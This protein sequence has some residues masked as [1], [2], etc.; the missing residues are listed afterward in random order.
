MEDLVFSG[1]VARPA[2]KLDLRPRDALVSA[3]MTFWRCLFLI[4]LVPGNLRGDEDTWEHRLASRFSGRLQRLELELSSI[5]ETLPGLPDVPLADQGGSGGFVSLHSQAEPPENGEFSV[6]VRFPSSG[7]V[8]LVV[9]V[10]ARRYGAMGLESQFGLP[11][12][13]RVEL[14]DGSDHSIALV[15]EPHDLWVNP[16]RAGHPFVFQVTPPVHAA[17]LKIKAL[18]LRKESDMSEPFV[19]AWAEVFAFE[20]S[21]NLALNGNVR[22]SGGSPSAAPWQWSNAFLTDSQTPLGLPEVPAGPHP[23]VGWMEEIP[24]D[25]RSPLWVELDLGEVREF[26]AVRLIPAKRPTSDLPSGFGFPRGLTVQVLDRSYER[27]ELEPLPRGAARVGNPGH[28]SVLV[29]LGDVRGRYVKI[30]M[31]EL[32]K[33]YDN[34]PGF[35]ALSEIEVLKGDQNLAVGS[36]VR[37]S[38]N[39]GATMGSDSQIW[40]LASLSDGF[41]PEGK[42]VTDRAWLL[43]LD[44]RVG[45]EMQRYRLRGESREIVE[46]WRG[47]GLTAATI[48]GIVATSLLVASP[49]RYRIRSKRQLA[50]VR[51]RIAGDLHDEVGSNLG[52]IQMLASVAEG[53]AENTKE[54]KRIQRIAAETVSAVRDIVWLLRPEGD[55]RIGTVEHLRE[56]TSIMLEAHDWKFTANEAAWQCELRDDTN[57]HLFLY[58]REALHNILRHA[59]ARKVAIDV[60]YDAAALR[61]TIGD[62]GGGISQERLEN[63]ATL[64]ALRKRAE[65]LNAAFSV[66]SELAKG[67]TLEL[68]VPLAAKGSDKRK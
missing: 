39:S 11:D 57:R 46:R 55:H 62:D 16:V 63:P 58:F 31:L 4:L 23:E 15:S 27:P 43:A 25:L 37:S 47:I 5:G 36:R 49:I 30:N 54:L 61:L 52:S 1:A 13:F 35:V 41:G 7:L 28:N 51:D 3:R 38:I 6:S 53:R 56:T 14:L 59:E 68:V 8:D 18:K 21:R 48:F 65:T 10:P 44:Q 22:S 42:L 20:G 17:G 9:L 50:E 12:S 66:K 24:T 32:W 26:D 33:P 2:T 29:S 40:D 67:T 19:H 45:L 60:A 34:F 64:S